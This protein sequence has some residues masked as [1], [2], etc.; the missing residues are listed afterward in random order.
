MK[1]NAVVESLITE[2]GTEQDQS[3]TEEIVREISKAFK[4]QNVPDQKVATLMNVGRALK[5]LGVQ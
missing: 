5:A 1:L 4:N 3:K 2:F